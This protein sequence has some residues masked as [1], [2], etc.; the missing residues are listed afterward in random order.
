[1]VQAPSDAAEDGFCRPDQADHAE[2]A[3]GQWQQ[4]AW[5]PVDLFPEQHGPR[6]GTGGE[7][8]G[9]CCRG[10]QGGMSEEDRDRLAKLVRETVTS[11]PASWSQPGVDDAVLAHLE[12]YV[13]DPRRQ[14][15]FK[16][17]EEAWEQGEA[18][19]PE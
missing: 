6:G 4:W 9:C 14:E 8:Y 12:A 18:P 13:E 10:G 17:L 16:K 19:D 2:D 3:N 15:F 1:M 7:E 5:N 11:R